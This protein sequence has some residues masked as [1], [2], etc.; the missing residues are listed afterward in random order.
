MLIHVLV[1]P[2][3]HET[4]KSFGCVQEMHYLCQHLAQRGGHCHGHMD[5]W[6]AH[7]V[8]SALFLD[9]ECFF[10]TLRADVREILQVAAA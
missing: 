3:K 10:A 7:E 6:Q 2:A 1:V 4:K 5:Q 9:T 8:I